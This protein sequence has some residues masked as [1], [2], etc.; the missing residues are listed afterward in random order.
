[1]AKQNQKE[2]VSRGLLPLMLTVAGFFV[3]VAILAFIWIDQKPATVALGGRSP[4]ARVEMLRELREREA[5][6]LNTYGWVDQ[7][8]GVVRL[9]V[10]RAMQLVLQDLNGGQGA[11]N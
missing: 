9:P 3:F 4:E 7:D 2:N 5:S 1:M 6:E 8:Q 10:E 11:T